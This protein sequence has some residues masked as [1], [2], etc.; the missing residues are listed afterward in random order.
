MTK[1]HY[2]LM[3]GLRG[4]AALSVAFLHCSISFGF[5]F[6]NHCYLAVD[7][8]FCLSGFVIAY[9]YEHKLANGSLSYR[10]FIVLRVVRLYPMIFLGVLLGVIANA[11]SVFGWKTGSSTALFAEGVGA[12]FLLPL[13]LFFEHQAF[14]INNPL[15]SLHF[16]FFANAIYP[17]TMKWRNNF[18]ACLI[19]ILLLGFILILVSYKFSGISGL[20]FNSLR[21]YFGG[22]SRV[23]LPFSIGVIICRYGV[24]MPSAIWYGWAPILL[25]AVLF[26]PETGARWIYDCVAVI[27]LLP[28]VLILSTEARMSPITGAVFQWLGDISYPFYAIHMPIILGFEHLNRVQNNSVPASILTV[29]AIVVALISAQLAIKLFDKPIRRALTPVRS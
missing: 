27:I 3:D 2:V 26:A 10:E 19:I 11:I 18:W 16:E 20:G 4:V 22:F 29:G 15:W 12:L 28:I 9:A 13:G 5:E 14:S 24:R 25:L 6:S 8:F 7:F 17:L 1:K 23:V 21:S